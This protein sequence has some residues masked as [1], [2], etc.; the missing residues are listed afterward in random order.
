V[1]TVLAPSFGAGGGEPYGSALDDRDRMLSLHEYRPESGGAAGPGDRIDIGR[2]RDAAVR[3]DEEAIEDADGPILDVGCGPGRMVRAAALRGH[4]VL[5]VDVSA[6]AVRIA[7]RQG[8][9]VLHRSVFDRLPGEG[10]WGTA[11]L[12]DGNIGI[13]GDPGSL[14]RRCAT[15]VRPD[16]GRV[17]V[18]THAEP[19]RDRILRSVVIDDL[20]RRSLPFAWA[21]VGLDALRRHA[22]GAGLVQR[23]AWVRG[24]RSFAEYRRLC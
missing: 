18:E 5:G 16:E 2:F 11:I 17:V 3:G 23:R 12:M 7:R 15:M 19:L 24:D 13:G 8:L 9:P 20:G 21:E 6:A 4:V 22:A 10:R 14:L 1:P